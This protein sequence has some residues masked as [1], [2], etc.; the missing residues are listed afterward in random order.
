[1]TRLEEIRKRH[2]EWQIVH[3]DVT[4]LFELVEKQKES[5]KDIAEHSKIPFVKNDKTDN[6]KWL[7]YCHMVA[8]EALEGEE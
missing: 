4:Y 2:A 8:M 1:M 3:S 5:L 6:W 7:N